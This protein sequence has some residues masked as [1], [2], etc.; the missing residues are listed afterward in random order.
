MNTKYFLFPF[1]I[2][3]SN[4]MFGQTIYDTV[5]NDVILIK[6]KDVFSDGSN[7]LIDIPIEEQETPIVI[8]NKDKRIPLSLFAESKS[9]LRNQK[10]IILIT[11][12][13]EFIKENLELQKREVIKIKS[14]QNK[15]YHIRRSSTNYNIDSLII[16][17][18]S[19]PKIILNYAN[20]QYKENEF[21]YY[22]TDCY[23]NPIF[24]PKWK[25]YYE[26]QQKID[27]LWKNFNV[28]ISENR[29]TQYLGKEG[30]HCTYYTLSSFSLEQ[31]LKLIKEITELL[32]FKDNDHL[33]DFYFYPK[34][35]LPNTKLKVW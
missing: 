33:K 9:F 4:L 25:S 21:H 31:K 32:R 10:E 23:A 5:F 19:K 24:D 15:I 30:E 7:V 22:L 14:Y 12:D 16:T 3:L 2:L 8:L 6:E 20:K 13:W 1:F 27:S 28:N 11:P 35:Y 29:E 17:L 18:H 34:I 26:N